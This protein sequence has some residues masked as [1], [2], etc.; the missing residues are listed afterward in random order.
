MLGFPRRKQNRAAKVIE[1]IYCD[2]LNRPELREAP[3]PRVQTR[4]QP[5]RDDG[6]QR[7]G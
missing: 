4:S 1:K 3:T 5:E 6:G 2:K 7:C